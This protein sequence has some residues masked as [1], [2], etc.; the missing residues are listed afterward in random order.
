M[1]L[2]YELVYSVKITT[3]A[4]VLKIKKE[5]SLLR[6]CPQSRWVGWTGKEGCPV[7][8]FCRQGSG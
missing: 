4:G 2:Q 6:N 3:D 5:S 8:T 1:I 7:W